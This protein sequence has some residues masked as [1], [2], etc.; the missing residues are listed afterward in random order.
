MLKKTLLSLLF[1]TT[2]LT[3][4]AQLEHSVSVTGGFAY[5]GSGD[6]VGTVVEGAYSFYINQWSLTG[7]IGRADFSGYRNGNV[8]TPDQGIYD[9][10]PAGRITNYRTAD[11]LA[12]Y[13]KSF[14][15]RKWNLIAR[16]GP[17]LARVSSYFIDPTWQ[18]DDYDVL[19]IGG[20]AEVGIGYTVFKT[21]TATL[22]FNLKASGRK[23]INTNDGYVRLS[24]GITCRLYNQ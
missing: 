1:T 12:G 3:S 5:S 13:S 20:V 16:V 10:V 19:D 6:M 4:T 9:Y 22:D 11:V 7:Q 23:Y 14:S 18:N 17:S 8:L 2:A 21:G 15:N 24:A